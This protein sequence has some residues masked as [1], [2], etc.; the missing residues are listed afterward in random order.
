MTNT[1]TLSDTQVFSA[2]TVGVLVSDMTVHSG[3]TF[4]ESLSVET[5]HRV[6]NFE[7]AS[8]HNYIAD[9][10]RVHNKSI[11]AA[12]HDHELAGLV[13]VEEDANGNLVG[14]EVLLK[15]ENGN[16]LG[17]TV[18]KSKIVNGVQL[19]DGHTTFVG[20][21][22]NGDEILLQTQ[23]QRDEN[24]N[25]VGQPVTYQLDGTVLGEQVGSL[26]T[27]YLVNA[28]I[29]DDANP[30][31]QFATNTVI[32]T[33]LENTLEFA[34]GEIHSIL[35]NW[36]Q[37][38]SH[39]KTDTDTISKFS[40]GD[41]KLD[42]AENAA[43]SATS[44][45]TNW[46]MGEVFE[47]LNNGSVGGEI[48]S[49]LAHH[50]INHLLDTGLHALGSELSWGDKLLKRLEP[51]E[52]LG[53]TPKSF[54]EAITT[55][56]G[57]PGL[58][59]QT[60]FKRLLPQIETI[61]G[62]IADGAVKLAISSFTD[63]MAAHPATMIFSAIVGKIFDNLFEKTPTAYTKVIYKKDLGIFEVASPVSDDGGNIELALSIAKH[64]V[65]FMN[66][67][68]IQTQSESN[69]F[70]EIGN[71]LRLVFGHYEESITNGSGRT[72]NTLESAFKARYVDTIQALELNDGDLK[73]KSALDAVKLDA[74]F[75]DEVT[76]FGSYTYWKKFFFIKI[77]KKT[78]FTEINEEAAGGVSNDELVALFESWPISSN[79]SI[80]GYLISQANRLY[81][82]L[83]VTD[84][85][86]TAIF[87]AIA[88]RLV[89]ANWKHALRIGTS[90]I[91]ERGDSNFVNVFVPDKDK[92]G[93]ILGDVL[94]LRATILKLQDQGYSFSTE[95]EFIAALKASELF[96]KSKSI[97]FDEF[98]HNLQIA[99]DYHEYL[100]NQT[101]YDVAISAAGPNSAY[102][103]G[104]ALTF[105]E[106]AR[107]GY[108]DGYNAIGD[109]LHNRF[110]A[111]SGNDTISSGWGDDTI[112]SFGG[113][114]S[115]FGGAGAD[116]I[117]A[118]AG[119]DSVLGGQGEDTLYGG[120]GADLLVG[121]EGNDHLI[122][123]ASN[124]NLN[125]G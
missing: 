53:G 120:K 124:D 90:I 110:L 8:H 88:D 18:F 26:L 105:M 11:L 30:F 54:G 118:G 31:E 71:E 104:W 39:S 100:E 102:A 61:E 111:G 57:I 16:T 99:L 95:S 112:S 63:L 44:L 51:D 115:L 21:D 89:S 25:A 20:K 5:T 113:D 84:L 64:Y 103:Q 108:N 86:E 109:T 107:L 78:V 70:A 91:E 93:D 34:G 2:S 96:I 80:F 56:T 81:S 116:E 52:F 40:F 123:G 69:N 45:M 59:F 106:A 50:G 83:Q 41:F 7:V 58:I 97:L 13:N 67:L 85:Q 72:F 82:D 36:G 27:P 66:E 17:T 3:S 62:R 35:K 46:I 22:A 19:R 28:L 49:T 37:P 43:E 73:V 65:E 87:E 114:D 117:H 4:E 12:L 55:G 101:A 32:G 60:V 77:T 92:A 10:V 15:D 42:L 24:G 47:G 1:G 121:E 119:N 125:G 6:Y 79:A 9:G 29:G 74:D 33:L 48:A 23:F 122:G 94:Y 75:L 38:D 98:Q 68:V 76:H 14:A